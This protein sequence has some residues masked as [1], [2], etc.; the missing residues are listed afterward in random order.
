MK[1]AILTLPLHTNYGGIIQAYA[2]QTVLKNMGHEVS[3]LN[4]EVYNL[5]GLKKATVNLKRLIKNILLIGD[6]ELFEEEKK[7]REYLL[8]RN[9]IQQFIDSKLDNLLNTIDYRKVPNNFDAIVVG[10]DQV[11][12]NKYFN[13]IKHAYLKFAEKWN[14][15]RISFAASFG[16][17]DFSYTERQKNNCKKLAQKFDFISVRE[18]SG[19]DICEKHLNVKATHVLDPTMLLS[20]SDYISIINSCKKEDEIIDG[21]LFA[22]VLDYSDKIESIICKVCEKLNYQVYYASTDRR[23]VGLEKR[24]TVKMGTWLNY[25]YNAEMIIADSFHAC[26]FSII[27]KKPFFVILNNIGNERIISLLNMFN[28]ENRII[29]NIHSIND[30]ALNGKIDWD[31]VNS[32]LRINK[33]TSLSFLK[34]A[35]AN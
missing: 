2:L 5:P 27:F 14:I 1:L 17:A 13:P 35:L 24:K 9:N 32:V 30:E 16:T 8:I 6:E 15:K 4:K 18:K 28:L 10:S 31:K 29:D 12:N 21:E 3:I 23:D 25:F 11:W 7:R 22:Y 20:V 33:E 26:V 19:V 34:N